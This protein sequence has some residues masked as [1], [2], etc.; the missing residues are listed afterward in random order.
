MFVNTSSSI[1]WGA[2]LISSLAFAACGDGDGEENPNGNTDGEFVLPADPFNERRCPEIGDNA[3]MQFEE[4]FENV[5]NQRFYRGR[6]RVEKSYGRDVIG[7][8]NVEQLLHGRYF[9]SENVLPGS[10]NGVA[11]E[12]V[13]IF[14]SEEGQWINI[15]STTTNAD[16]FYDFDIPAEHQVGVGN[17]RMLAVLEATGTCNEHGV[18]VWPAQTKSVISDIDGTLT[19]DDAEFLSQLS[20]NALIPLQNEAADAMMQAWDDKGFAVTYLTARPNEFRWLSR[21]WL[22]EEGFPFG[23]METAETFVYGASAREYKGRFVTA[24]H[25]LNYEFAAA[26]G[27]AE[28]DVQAYADGGIPKAVTFTINEAAGMDGTVAISPFDWTSHISEFVNPHAT[29]DN[30]F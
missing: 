29:T 12:R 2:V 24:M 10:G 16:G 13:Q 14:A 3:H 25:A 27:N 9:R 5:D 1:L 11:G 28:S 18:F 15:G 19:R 30:G 6:F 21:V 4:G 17:H 22:R 23:P 7:Q 8:E 26:Y 20:N